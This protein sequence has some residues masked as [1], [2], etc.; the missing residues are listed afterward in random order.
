[1]RTRADRLPIARWHRA[2]QLMTY[3]TKR[4]ARNQL[5]QLMS[6]ERVPLFLL[7]GHQ[8]VR[9]GK[10]G[11][12]EASSATTATWKISRP[13]LPAAT[14]VHL[15]KR[16]EAVLASGRLRRGQ[17]QRPRHH[18]SEPRLS[19]SSPAVLNATRV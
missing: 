19:G 14:T 11:T 3:A 1:M 16:P 5:G 17:H 12:E 7:G 13:I 2:S 6:A 8:V 18:M 10:L 9:P 4:T 15:R